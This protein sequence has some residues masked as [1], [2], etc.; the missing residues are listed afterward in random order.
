ML[1]IFCLIVISLLWGITNPFIKRGGIG[2]GNI[3]CSNKIIELILK[4]KFIILN[5]RCV[6]PLVINQCGSLLFIATLSFA[7][8]FYVSKIMKKYIVVLYICFK[9][10]S[11]IL[12]Y[13]KL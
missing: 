3:S 1:E 12:K 9:L 5:W 10:K 6:V 7:S 11:T 8:N 13:I 2:I 4:L